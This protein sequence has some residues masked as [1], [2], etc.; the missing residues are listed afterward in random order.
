MKKESIVELMGVSPETIKGLEPD[1]Y[2]VYM[3]RRARYLADLMAWVVGLLV[4][5]LVGVLL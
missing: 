5:I 1:P 4:V 3:A 2:V